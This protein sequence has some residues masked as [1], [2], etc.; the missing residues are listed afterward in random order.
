MPSLFFTRAIV[1]GLAAICASATAQSVPPNLP[2]ALGKVD[3][4]LGKLAPQRPGVV[5]AYVLVVSLDDDPVFGREAREAARVLSR[6]FD[7][8]G[9]TLLLSEIEGNAVGDGAGS[10]AT[11]DRALSGIASRMDRQEDVL[12]LYA[13]THGRPGDGLIYKAR[14]AAAD[15]ITPYRLASM[16]NRL[17]VPN[18]LIILQACYSGQFIPSLASDRTVVITA[19]ARDRP[20]FGCTPGNDWT[21]FG[22]AFVNQALRKPAPL[23]QQFREARNLIGKWERK[24]GLQPSQPQISIGRNTTLWLQPLEARA[25]QTATAPT[26]QPPEE[27]AN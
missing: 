27:L 13:T 24:A 4:A 22:H 16:L 17:D 21:F 3:A 2:G 9:R 1:A 26:G 20:S 25:P 15:A 5:D 10:P 11:L 7:A 23:A 18:R 14:G 8:A 12:V 19:A 6:R